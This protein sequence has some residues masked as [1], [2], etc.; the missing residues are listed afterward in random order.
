MC[1]SW[2][3]DTKRARLPPPGDGAQGN[4]ES[5]A[6]QH[7][8]SPYR[9]GLRYTRLDSVR[10][11][12]YIRE[13]AFAVEGGVEAMEPRDKNR[14]AGLFLR[15][16]DTK[17]SFEG[18]RQEDWAGSEGDLRA[19]HRQA[20]RPPF[21]TEVPD[22]DTWSHSHLADHRLVAVED[23]QVVGWAAL[24]PFSQ[25]ECYSGV[26]ENSVYVKSSAQGRGIG[27]ALLE[28]LAADPPIAEASG[29]SEPGSSRRTRPSR[30]SSRLRVRSRHQ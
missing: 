4:S 26:A 29:R 5:A 3:A 28:R 7:R 19:G 22:W 23:E 10:S 17:W 14:L 11:P 30:A 20:A 9:R 21:E 27:R 15:P 1:C 6:R 25:R 16:P 2:C 13:Q 12:S 24:A 8:A 18:M